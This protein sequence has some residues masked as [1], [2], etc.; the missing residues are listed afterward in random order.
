MHLG[1]GLGGRESRVPV[2]LGIELVRE[3]PIDAGKDR[4][5]RLRRRGLVPVRIVRRREDGVLLDG[6]V[7]PRAR[8]AETLGKA[9]VLLLRLNQLHSLPEMLLKIVHQLVRVQR[10]LG[11]LLLEQM[12]HAHMALRCHK[13]EWPATVVGEAAANEGGGL[14]AMDS[15]GAQVGGGL[16]I[17]RIWST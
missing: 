10:A 13:E 9:V 16:G 1:C 5:H 8:V 6:G 14:S 4:R 15:R 12:V 3:A 2:E 17:V 11:E 7:I